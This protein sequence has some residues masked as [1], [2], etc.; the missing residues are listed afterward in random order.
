MKTRLNEKKAGDLKPAEAGYE[1]RDE[2]VRGLILRV[3]KKGQKV[4]EV[5]LH[6]GKKRH[7]QRLGT[8]PAVSVK[9][10]RKRAEAA[11]E[12]MTSFRAGDGPKTVSDIFEAYKAARSNEMRTWHDVQSVWDIWARDR[13]GHV[14]VADLNAHHGLDL[15]GHVSKN[16]SPLRAGAVIRYLRPMLHW[17]VDEQMIEANPWAGL[18]VGAKAQSRDRVLSKSEWQSIW[19]ASF[20]LEYPFGP[21]IRTLMLTAQRL[22]NVAQMRWDEIQDDLWT[23]P[24]EKMKATKTSKAKA[25]EVPF[26]KAVSDLIAKQP[27]R[28]TFVFTT[29][30]DKPIHPGSK[31]KAKLQHLSKTND[32]RF[33][34]IRRTAATR[35]TSGNASGKANRFI[36]ERVLGHADTSVT[37]VYDRATYRSEK[38]DA[39]EV[40]ASSVHTDF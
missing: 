30:G 14:R 16:S 15:R 23:I 25:H 35:M 36:V 2:I 26:S 32:W 21:F 40:L 24:R 7:R 3:G 5:V 6:V 22:N 17:A 13:I 1:V 18:K 27:N 33:H 9:D 8:F 39:L 20:Q 4:W 31:I 11:K 29:T 37:A 10:A 19:A 28:G 12:S 38:R 34:D